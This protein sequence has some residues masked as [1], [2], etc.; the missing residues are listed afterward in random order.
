MNKISPVPAVIVALGIALAGWFIGD[1]F[2]SGRASDRFVTVKGVS[3]RDVKADT[4]LWPIRFVATSDR[5]DVAQSSIK[6]SHEKVLSFL[7]GQGVESGSIEVQKLEVTDR[8]ANPYGNSGPG[9][10][11]YIIAETVMVRSDDADL[12]VKASQAVGELVDAGVVIS[13]MGGP[14]T[15]PTYL[16]T[17]LS[18][19]KPEM[20]AEAT[21]NARRAGEQFAVDSGA[22]LGSIR[23][24]NQGL[25]VI[26]PRDRAMGI[27]EEGEINKTVRVVST[28]DFYLKD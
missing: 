2:I 28:I 8:L 18:E 16:F 21:A 12:V 11:R 19:L 1:G 26:L 27:T 6:Q 24:A 13:T 17:Q 14:Q 4:A 5:L 9:T 22:E 23:R 10:S 15:G 20:I 3:E 7:K 25:F